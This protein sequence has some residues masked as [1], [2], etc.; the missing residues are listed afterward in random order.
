MA[1]KKEPPV[2]PEVTANLPAYPAI[3]SGA[4]DGT[5]GGLP[6]TPNPLATAAEA[7][8]GATAAI[9]DL[10]E[11]SRR[12]NTFGWNQYAGRMPGYKDMAAQSST[13]IEAAL[14]GEVP[15]DVLYQLQQQAAERGGGG[16]GGGSP[17]SPAA[18][19][20]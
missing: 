19:R 9:P 20:K 4:Y 5:V 7:V 13:N 2:R 16:G 10:K 3:P 6:A 15:E 18:E 8:K 14:R 12:M 1:K 17:C 11:L